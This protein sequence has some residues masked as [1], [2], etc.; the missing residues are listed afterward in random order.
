M[1][2]EGYSTDS[3]FHTSTHTRDG[4]TNYQWKASSCKTLLTNDDK[5]T[6]EPPVIE[7]EGSFEADWTARVA[8][9][10]SGPPQL[11]APP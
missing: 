3:T 6:K 10:P 8:Q 4:P 7:T 2:S 9:R 1:I 11:P 5:I